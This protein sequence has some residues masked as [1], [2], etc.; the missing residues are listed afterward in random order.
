MATL[1]SNL[2]P[3][4]PAYTR[5]KAHMLDLVEQ[6]R[7]LEQRAVLR[8]ARSAA[9]FHE[10]GKLLPRERL[11]HLL[12]PGRPFLE[13][14][15][16]AGY[17]GIEDR[18]PATSIPGSALIVGIGHISGVRCM[19]AAN[20]A[21]ISAG[22]MQSLT[23]QKLIRAQEIALAHKLPFVQLVESAGGNLKKYR[24]ERF[25][26]GGGMFYNLARLSA[27]GL[28]V[29]SLIHGSSAA[30]GAYLPGLSDYVVM[31]RQ[32]AR[33]FLAGPALLKAATGEEATEEELGGTDMHARASGLA[34]YVAENDLDGIARIRDILRSI[35]WTDT[36]VLPPSP[37]RPPRHDRED[38][39]GVMPADARTPV[40]MREV[41]A[42]LV[43]DSDFH[44]FKQLYGAP[45][46]CGYATVHGQPV[47]I[48]TNN[49]P[50]DPA[51]ATKAAEF[52][53]LCV[54][55]D[56][57]ILFLQ[58][59][60][61]FIVGRA[62]EEAGMIKHGAKL[63]QA[64]SNAPVPRIT[65]L[66]GASF[67]AGNYGMCGRAFKPDFLFSW[68][69]AKTAVM[70]G[71]QAAMTMRMVAEGAARRAGRA[72]NE[73]ALAQESREIVDN[74]NEQ[75]TAIYTSSLLLDDGIIDPRNTREV[76]G[77]VLKTAAAAKTRPVIPIQFG[78]A[79]F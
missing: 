76:L 43:D 29:I 33:A 47:G 75:S 21:G 40:D 55:L 52:I 26:V 53:Q 36:A 50:L 66:C 34:D 35:G 14:M 7:A 6:V 71:E 65:L 68:P 24:V 78:V 4:S 22:A 18:D 45:T 15:T 41:I 57:P 5:N 2:A 30:G 56:R 61:G 19:V 25:I 16:L 77:V 42:R 60:T 64:L 20:D 17:C 74:F 59:I 73:D 46:V 37:I 11:A 70:G 39:L 67:G 1:A 10:R 58:N 62:H 12:D 54:Q 38:L 13:L 31:V 44:E 9:N 51:G 3:A 8:S 27:A 79:R 28:P 23:G 69:N 72:V 63:I 49:G 48:L 32:Q